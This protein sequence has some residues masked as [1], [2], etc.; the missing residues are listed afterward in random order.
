[1]FRVALGMLMAA[2]SAASGV[3]ILV[4]PYVS[5]AVA[6]VVAGLAV[7]PFALLWGPLAAGEAQVGFG[8]RARRHRSEGDVEPSRGH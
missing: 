2:A 3:L 5:A 8:A 4:G 6:C 1:M 7:L